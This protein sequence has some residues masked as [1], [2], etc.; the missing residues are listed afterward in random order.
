MNEN[1]KCNLCPRRCNADRI[2][3]QKGFC[4]M[5]DDV[6]IARA[7][8]HMWEEPCIS[9][10][11]GSGAVFFSGCQLRCVFCQNNAISTGKAGRKISIAE[12]AQQFLKLQEQKANNINLVTP[13]HY[14]PQIIKALSMAKADGLRIPV[15]YNT[16]SYENVET[17]K[18]LE[19]Y[20]DVYL[21]DLK[22]M[23]NHIAMKYSNAGDYFDIA[24]KAIAEML[25]QTGKPQF[26]KDAENK[27]CEAGIMK[28][29]VIVRHLIMPG[30]TKDSK[31]IVK[32]LYETYSNDIYISI[33]N[34]YTPLKCVEKYPELN[35]KITS[36]EYDDVVDY[37]IELGVENGFIQEGETAQ[38][39][40]I[41]EFS[42]EEIK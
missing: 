20:V 12:L 39:S 5:T 42:L 27:Y 26:Y 28:K 13:T 3:K 31:N 41:P 4:Q 18:M 37:A 33:M 1:D 7:A 10:E 2:H 29:G 38:E 11:N 9:G 8:L 30:M 40:F 16:S 36:E 15:V 6:Y 34:Q 23:D 21:P 22:Y 32:Y 17:L 19:G 24:S 14:V 35:R 25:R